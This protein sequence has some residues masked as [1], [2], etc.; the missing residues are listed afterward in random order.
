MDHF[1]KIHYSSLFEF[2]FIDYIKGFEF[3]FIALRILIKILYL[4][5]KKRKFYIT[6]ETLVLIRALWIMKVQIIS[7]L[8]LWEITLTKIITRLNWV[9]MQISIGLLAWSLDK[10]VLNLNSYYLVIKKKKNSPQRSAKH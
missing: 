7:K 5:L 10:F 4:I 9:G 6:E 8:F 1:L 2:H 3:Y